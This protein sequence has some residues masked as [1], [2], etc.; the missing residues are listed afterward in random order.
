MFFAL[1]TIGFAIAAI[2]GFKLG[3]FVLIYCTIGCL[4]A[5]AAYSINRTF[6]HPL[7]SGLMDYMRK[8]NAYVIGFVILTLP[9]LVL[10][11]Y[12]GWRVITR[13]GITEPTPLVNSLIGAF[14]LSA[15]YW[16]ILAI[17]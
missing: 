5:Y 10:I 7:A 9:P 13:Y 6:F 2:L 1:K 16:C 12:L 17:T 14:Y 3:F 8:A 11:P 4:T 15:I